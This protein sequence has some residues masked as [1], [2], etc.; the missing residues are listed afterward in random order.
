[1]STLP[2]SIYVFNINPIEILARFF[3]DTDKNYS[4]SYVERQCLSRIAE[5]V[6][7]KENAVLTT[8]LPDFKTLWSFYS[9]DCMVLAEGHTHSSVNRIENPGIDPHTYVQVIFDN[10]AKIIQWRNDSLSTT[11]SEVIRHP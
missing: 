6:L 2:K 5:V 3:K 11:G 1:M 10:G 9:Q 7:E 4:K 8:D